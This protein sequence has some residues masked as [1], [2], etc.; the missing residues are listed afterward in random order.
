MKTS[1]SIKFKFAYKIQGVRHKKY[2]FIRYCVSFTI[3]VKAYYSILSALR[4]VIKGVH[5]GQSAH[6]HAHRK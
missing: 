1:L 6:G 5:N 2:H 3:P 4:Q